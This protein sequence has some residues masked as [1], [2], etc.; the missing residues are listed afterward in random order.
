MNGSSNSPIHLDVHMGPLCPDSAGAFPVLLQVAQHYGPATLK[1]TLHMFPLPYHRQSYFTAIGAE[2]V[3]AQRGIAQTFNY[4]SA[5]YNDLE[6]LGNAKTY[7]MN[8]NDVNKMLTEIATSSAGVNPVQFAMGLND[9]AMET[10]TR[11]A[12]KYSAS[13]G[14][15]STPTF[16]LNDVTVEADPGWTLSEW[17]QVI[18]PLLKQGDFR[19]TNGTCPSGEISC[20]YLPGKFQCCLKGENCIPNVGCRCFRGNNC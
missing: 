5:I 18:D 9:F 11:T 15:A 16:F 19:S 1:L 6:N 7:L 10:N 20:E 13:R 4:I 2:V 17:Q 3:K 14:V 12:W 8:A